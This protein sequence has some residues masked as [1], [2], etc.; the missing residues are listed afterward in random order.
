MSR[1]DVIS[2][3]AA[4]TAQPAYNTITSHVNLVA[5]GPELLA[6]TRGATPLLREHFK[7]SAL[8]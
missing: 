5:S 7:I 6:R 8:Y 3:H 2:I 4:G 1:R